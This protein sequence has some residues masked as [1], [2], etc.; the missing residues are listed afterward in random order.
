MTR[1][2]NIRLDVSHDDEDD[3]VVAYLTLPDHPGALKAKVKK[4]VRIRD[5]VGDYIGPDLFLE[6]DENNVLVGVE[7]LD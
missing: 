6:F 3:E 5:V 2:Q 7:I 4:S 1:K